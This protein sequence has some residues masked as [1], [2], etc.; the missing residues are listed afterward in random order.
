[1]TLLQLQQEI[2]EMLQEHP[3][4]A[5]ANVIDGENPQY[6]LC[7]IGYEVEHDAVCINFDEE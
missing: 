2:N 7:S 5:E 6:E 1:M 4:L 3:N